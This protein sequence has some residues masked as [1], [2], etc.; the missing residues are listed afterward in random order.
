MG[1]P[2][3]RRPST[4]S[5]TFY[6]SNTFLMTTQEHPRLP[7]LGWLAR[8]MPDAGI[9][10]VSHGSAV[11][12]V[13][14]TGTSGRKI[15]LVEGIWDAPFCGAEFDTSPNFFGSGVKLTADGTVT[16]VPSRATTDRLMLVRDGDAIL[17]SNSLLLLL[18]ETEA[19][20]LPGHSYGEESSSIAKGLDRYTRSFKVFHPNIRAFTQIYYDNVIVDRAGRISTRRP[21]APP[22][23]ENYEAYCST[24]EAI[25]ARMATNMRAEQRQY[26]MRGISTISSGYDSPAVAALV[27]KV[28]VD[29]CFTATRSNTNVP[30]FV[31]PAVN[32]D[33]GGPIAHALGLDVHTLTPPDASVDGQNELYFLA[34]NR[35]DP[36]L[37]FH[38]LAEHVGK[39]QQIGVVF[40]G[41]YGDIIW[42]RNPKPRYVENTLARDDVSGSGLGEIRLHAGFI[43]APVPYLGARHV[44]AMA[45][46]SQ[47]S[48]M[49]RWSVGGS[50]DRPIP[51][52]ILETRG[53][54]RASFGTRKKAVAQEYVAPYNRD[55]RRQF[56]RFIESNGLL[57]RARTKVN[58]VLYALAHAQARAKAWLRGRRD[59]RDRDK[60][61]RHQNALASTRDLRQ[62]LYV[63]AT[64]LLADHLAKELRSPPADAPATHTQESLRQAA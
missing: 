27:Q 20:L 11:E 46:I 26:P 18:A 60:P 56:F 52:R 40:T 4:K 64:G 17:V 59:I 33:D 62:Q 1:I 12:K 63:F 6:S 36:E 43:N 37:I 24:L 22:P 5:S 13:E 41:Y 21:K 58:F 45:A 53:V 35:A 44:A 42:A 7:K 49:A 50:Y 8:V 51:R 15:A 3:P 47:S 10:H 16:F 19:R 14:S 30:R 2:T 28:G 39:S 29:T 55:I 31:D 23:P 9:V 48:T 34:S 38:S 61:Q 32:N 57:V 54:S 25:L